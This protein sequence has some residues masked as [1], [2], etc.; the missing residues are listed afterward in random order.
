MLND[1]AA[2]AALLS[3]LGVSGRLRSL[4]EQAF[5]NSGPIFDQRFGTRLFGRRTTRKARENGVFRLIF[6]H[7]LASTTKSILTSA[8]R[9]GVS[10]RLF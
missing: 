8:K 2:M 3:P 6:P 7:F 9:Q 4:A 1:R 5:P 10:L